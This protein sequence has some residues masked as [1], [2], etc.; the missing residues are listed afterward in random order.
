MKLLSTSFTFF[1]KIS[2]PFVI[3]VCTICMLFFFLFAI[4]F[5][6]FSLLSAAIGFLAFWLYG[7]IKQVEMDGSNLYV[8]NYLNTEEIPLVALK[9]VYEDRILSTSFIRLRFKYK[10]KFGQEIKFVPHSIRNYFYPHPTA[11]ELRKV[12]K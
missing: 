11:V 5:W 12:I 3:L 10:T 9:E 1:I 6:I 8:S 2:V 4:E 7:D